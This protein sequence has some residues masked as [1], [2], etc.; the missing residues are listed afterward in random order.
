MSDFEYVPSK[1][2]VCSPTRMTP[3]SGM[4]RAFERSQDGGLARAGWADDDGHRAAVDGEVDAAQN[5]V[6]AEGLLQ[7]GDVD[8]SL[9]LLADGFTHDVTNLPNRDSSLFCRADRTMHTIQ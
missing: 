8:D 5:V 6:V 4:S 2:I 9:R 1:S 7:P 3:A